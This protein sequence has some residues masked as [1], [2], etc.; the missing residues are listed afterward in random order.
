MNYNGAP[1]S[2]R[3]ANTLGNEV[4]EEQ[5]EKD[6]ELSSA[7]LE[8]SAS[9][10]LKQLQQVVVQTSRQVVAERRHATQLHDQIHALEAVVAEQDAMLD[11]LNRDNEA[12]QQE[13]AQLMRSYQ[14]E[15]R[16]SVEG[17]RGGKETG[18]SLHAFSSASS[19]ATLLAPRHNNSTEKVTRISATAVDQ[20]VVAEFSR[21]VKSFALSGIHN[22]DDDAV[23][24]RS[25]GGYG[26]ISHGN[27]FD[28]VAPDVAAVLR[29]LATQVLQLRQTPLATTEV[30][31]NKYAE[32][33]PASGSN[34]VKSNSAESRSVHSGSTS[35]VSVEKTPAVP[36]PAAAF[37]PA[38]QN[39]NLAKPAQP[40]VSPASQVD[41]PSAFHSTT[42]VGARRVS[43]TSIT[44]EHQKPS[45]E[46][47][48]SESSASV[49][50]SVYED[51]ATILSDI[52]ARYGL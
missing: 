10:L 4:V 44:A 39:R 22:C 40:T 6:V 38:S 8:A 45:Q 49:D 19:A 43:R 51:A 12:A 11:Q 5:T 29:S 50:S 35:P 24:R 15:L 9:T 42:A 1:S 16:R 27:P 14:Q 32:L 23:A 52:R 13:K 25:S 33:R 41:H 30:E 46:R 31:G 7:A 28:G 20:Y 36:P 18:G 37:L 47:A 3:D 21:V 34:Q 26:G 48:V 17:Q 2:K